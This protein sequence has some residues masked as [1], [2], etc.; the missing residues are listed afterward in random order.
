MIFALTLLVVVV[1]AL[2]FLEKYFYG[3]EYTNWPFIINFL[4]IPLNLI[5]SIISLLFIW[6]IIAPFFVGKKNDVKIFSFVLKR[7]SLNSLCLTVCAIFLFIF[8][9][10]LNNQLPTN[11]WRGGHPK[12]ELTINENNFYW[13]FEVLFIIVV[14]VVSGKVFIKE[15]RRWKEKNKQNKK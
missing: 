3:A 5:I 11:I 12:N 10:Y 4:N 15:I 13:I 6:L 14:V 8:C 1:R 7:N 2:A 9:S